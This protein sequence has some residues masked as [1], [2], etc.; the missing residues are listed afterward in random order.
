MACGLACIVTNV[1][2]TAKW[3]KNGETGYIIPV[4][5]PD[6]LAE[7]I[8]SLIKNKKLRQKMGRSNLQLVQQKANYNK[9]MAKMAE[10][11]DELIE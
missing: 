7:N 3:I 4:K 2:D 9:E 11:Y 8:I 1:G 5:R 10:I 6:M